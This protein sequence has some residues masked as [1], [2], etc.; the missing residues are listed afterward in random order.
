MWLSS[1]Q[2]LCLQSCAIEQR[3]V[4]PMLLPSFQCL[5]PSGQCYCPQANA[6]ATVLSS[7][8]LSP[9][10]LIPMLLSSVQCYCPQAN[11]IVFSPISLSSCLC[12]CPQANLVKC[13][14]PQFSV[15]PLRPIFVSSVVMIMTGPFWNQCIINKWTKWLGKKSLYF[16]FLHS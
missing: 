4:T 2:C 3:L 12:Y 13:Y 10:Q 15:S 1:G 7:V 9:G 16:K 6:Y 5:L 8:L 11:S 14:C